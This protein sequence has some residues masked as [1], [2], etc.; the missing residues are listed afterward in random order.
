LW[1]ECIKDKRIPFNINI[2]FDNKY[3]TISINMTMNLSKLKEIISDVYIFQALTMKNYSFLYREK[4]YE[5]SL[6]IKDI[7]N[8]EDII[9]NTKNKKKTEKVFI[10]VKLHA[11][12]IN[13]RALEEEKEF[14]YLNNELDINYKKELEEYR[15]RLD[16]IKDYHSIKNACI[17]V[18]I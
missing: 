8:Y 14:I 6:L 9:Y 4:I 11:N 3:M 18:I 1:E 12:Q 7:L 10:L 5:D 2:S 17:K 16:I 15:W 13:K